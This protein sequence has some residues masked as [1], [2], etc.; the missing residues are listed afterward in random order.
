MP[1]YEYQCPKGHTFDVFQKMSDPARKKCPKCGKMAQR[2]LSGGAGLIFKGAGFYITDNRPE[3][4]KKEQE[5]FE[6]PGAAFTPKEGAATAESGTK[7]STPKSS[8]AK[9]AGTK[10]SGAKGSSGKGSSGKK[11]RK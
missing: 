2:L 9:A 7:E 8:G 6:I 10:S 1:T 5:K 11:G 4:Y 3:S